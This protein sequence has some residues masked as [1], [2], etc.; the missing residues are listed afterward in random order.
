MSEP[1]FNKHVRPHLNEIKNGRAVWFKTIDLIAWADRFADANGKQNNNK[2]NEQCQN[3][4]RALEKGGVTGGLKKPCQVSNFTK[5][6]AKR[7]S[8]KPNAT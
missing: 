8:N 1:Y 4:Q 6:L 7:N 2:E 3:Q 5:A